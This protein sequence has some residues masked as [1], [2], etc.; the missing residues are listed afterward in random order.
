MNAVRKF[1]A[2]SVRDRW[3]FVEAAIFVT[4][5][6]LALCIVPF[7][8]LAPYLGR[9]MQGSTEKAQRADGLRLEVHRAVGRAARYLP[10]PAK[11]FSQ[12]IAGKLMLRRRGVASTLC[13]GVKKGGE[14]LEAHAWLRAGGFVVTGA[15]GMAGFTIVATFD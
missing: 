5:A 8:R 4:L 10:W 7:R 6:G 2:S 11:C 12:A 3:L 15:R 1:A 14:E 9:H 13:L